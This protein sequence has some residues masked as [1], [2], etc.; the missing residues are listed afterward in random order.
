VSATAF[1]LLRPYRP[2]LFDQ[3]AKELDGVAARLAAQAG[4]KLTE[5]KT[6]TV[7]GRKIRSYRFEAGSDAT[8]I[9]FVLDGRREVQLLCRAPTADGDP[10]GSCALLF[11]SFGLR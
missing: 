7:D 2:A 9:G 8:R 4:G 10:D 11:D 5:Q 3:A 1:P 6:T